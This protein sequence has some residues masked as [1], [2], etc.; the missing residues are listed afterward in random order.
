MILKALELT[1]KKPN[2]SKPN[3]QNMKVPSRPITHVTGISR[4]GTLSKLSEN[5][6]VGFFRE[7]G[8]GN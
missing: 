6:L 3:A 4:L 8:K 5:E 2:M 7:P 1:K